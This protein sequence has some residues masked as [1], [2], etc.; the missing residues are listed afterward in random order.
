MGAGRFLGHPV[1]TDVITPIQWA[2]KTTEEM[3]RNVGQQMEK[4][5]E[6]SFLHPLKQ[7]RDRED[8][9]T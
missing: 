3:S 8:P 9:D 6:Q 7:L 2:D 5:A 4:E 1:P